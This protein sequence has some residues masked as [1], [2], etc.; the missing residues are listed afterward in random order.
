MDSPSSQ[1]LSESEFGS[2]EKDS[3]SAGNGSLRLVFTSPNNCTTR[4]TEYTTE[5]AQRVA[6][7]GTLT[8]LFGKQH[9]N[10]IF[11]GHVDSGKSTMAGNLLFIT[12]MVSKR[13]LERYETEAKELGRESWYLSWALDSTT[14]ERSKASFRGRMA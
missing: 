4:D 3:L 5:E 11:V 1:K 8:A 7:E 12:G 9:L 2:A 10:I 14:Q 13:T 6:D